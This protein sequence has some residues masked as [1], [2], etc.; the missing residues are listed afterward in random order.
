MGRCVW[1]WSYEEQLVIYRRGTYPVPPLCH[2]PSCF[3]VAD[4]IFPEF[5]SFPVTQPISF[6]EPKPLML[7]LDLQFERSAF[8]SLS[9]AL[10]PARWIPRRHRQ[11]A[12]HNPSTAPDAGQRHKLRAG[13]TACRKK[14]RGAF[15]G[16]GIVGAPAAAVTRGT[17]CAGGTATGDPATGEK[18]S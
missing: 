3:L 11:K 13:T 4:S 8:F 6:C 1:L 7:E 18:E 2:P 5:V 15:R 17:P 14:P 9:Q 16:E 12:A 10:A